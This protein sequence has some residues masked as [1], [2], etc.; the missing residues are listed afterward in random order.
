M[1]KKLNKILTAIL[2]VA[3]A[4]CFVIALTSVTTA[5]AGTGT[6]E[7][8][9][10]NGVKVREEGNLGI[11]FTA[12]I[13][14]DDY[15]Q[16]KSQGAKFGMILAPSDWVQNNEDLNFQSTTL[17]EYG[18]Q[19]AGQNFF[20]KGL[21][22]PVL[23]ENDFDGDGDTT[24]Y[25]LNC[26]FIKIKES[27]F[28]RSFKARA[29]YQIGND[30]TYSENVV[31]TNVYTTAS[32]VVVEGTQNADVAT[33]VEG[34]VAK[35]IETYDLNVA[36]TGDED[37][38]T[39]G[40]DVSVTATVTDGTNTIETACVITLTR[41]DDIVVNGLTENN[42]G[43]YKLA[44]AGKVSV[45]A[46]IASETVTVKEL[47]VA[48]DTEVALSIIPGTVESGEDAR[49][50]S[51]A[52]LTDSTKVTSSDF[53]YNKVDAMGNSVKLKAVIEDPDNP[54]AT[55]SPED[56][57]LEEGTEYITVGNYEGHAYLA[58]FDRTKKIPLKT[59]V[60]LTYTDEYGIKHTSDPLP[61]YGNYNT[62]DSPYYGQV[63][64]RF[65]A[66]DAL[67]IE[68]RLVGSNTLWTTI[69]GVSLTSTAT[70][71]LIRFTIMNKKAD[72]A[73]K[74]LNKMYQIVIS[75]TGNPDNWVRICFGRHPSDG[76]TSMGINTNAWSTAKLAYA[77]RNGTF[78]TLK[79]EPTDSDGGW[80]SDAFSNIRNCLYGLN[81]LATDAT[82]YVG[83]MLGFSIVDSEVFVNY[84]KA[85]GSYNHWKNGDGTS[86]SIYAKEN[87]NN[88]TYGITPWNGFSN[89]EGKTV[90][91]SIAGTNFRQ[92]ESQYIIIDTLG[93]Q[94]VTADWINNMYYSYTTTSL[95][96]L[97]SDAANA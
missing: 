6:G 84:G 52:E 40:D 21:N 87:Q 70:E 11:Q 25:V 20:A 24:E 4:F 61:I 19:S 26:Y 77:S 27:N 78:N 39:K 2:A 34:I 79:N 95:P 67:I 71:D 64:D 41:N 68:N 91:I 93:G 83:E 85:D 23:D 53:Q 81:P 75:E 30:Y 54:D 44:T 60:T 16:L 51:F 37:G 36:L 94:K 45:M 46:T 1:S 88:E 50:T 72:L 74:L 29:F 7:I 48:R 89:F 66:T 10:I 55:V 69:K 65:T 15:T 63:A 62:F 47:D 32:K 13:S 22:T 31:E 97:E 3:F 43:S 96:Y 58:N 90:D 86:R 33:Y 17:V 76:Y 18:K 38:V 28:D 42:D 9:M 59:S 5:K 92:E 80:W 73:D 14:A 8:T 12:T 56:Y 35:V 49:W 57:T 82:K